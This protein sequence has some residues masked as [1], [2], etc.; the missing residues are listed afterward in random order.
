MVQS[1]QLLFVSNSQNKQLSNYLLNL[2]S[3]THRGIIFQRHDYKFLIPRMMVC[4]FS[5]ESKG[6]QECMKKPHLLDLNPNMATD[7]PLRPLQSYLSSL[8]LSF[9]I[10]TWNYNRICSIELQ[11]LSQLIYV[12]FLVQHLVINRCTWSFKYKVYFF[13]TL[14]HLAQKLRKLFHM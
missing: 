1:D 5:T 8:G 13:S 3:P 14:M 2:E 7:K 10:V 4:H 12:M 6:S 9:L 11:G